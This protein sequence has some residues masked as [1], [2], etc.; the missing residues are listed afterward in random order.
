M[1]NT[2]TNNLQQFS[3]QDFID[4][5]LTK[6]SI[7]SYSINKKGKLKNDS[8][9][10]FRQQF[11]I[12]K[13]K[14][15]GL[16]SSII[17]QSHGPS[18]LTWDE[19]ETYYDNNGQVIKE[20]SRPLNI[21]K[22]VE[23]G[24]TK[25]DVI[26]YETD[27]EYDSL[28][29]EIKKTYK[30]IDHYY[31]ISKHTKDTFHLH[32]IERPDID[33]YFYN[34][35]N[36]KVQWFRTV[37]STRYLKTENY[38]PEKDSNAV[39]CYYCHSRYLNVEWKYN[40]DKKLTEWISYTSENFIHTKQNYFYDEQ[41]RLIKQIDSTG[42]YFTTI[43]PYQES[44][45]TIQYADTGKIVAKIYNPK[46]RFAKAIP[47]INSYFDNNDR[48]I[49]QCEFFDTEENCTQHAFIYDK[50]KIIKEEIIFDDGTLSSTEFYYNEKGLIRENRIF[51]N[52]NLTTL[53]R[54][55]YELNHQ[56]D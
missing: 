36:Q 32:I 54:Y 17:Y 50:N 4:N 43:R 48:L 52:G 26:T 3:R 10:L 20:I 15:F 53:I 8:L 55:Y 29:R 22:S 47:K 23:F 49:K 34:S 35:D 40:A 9:L 27:Y 7:Y 11:D 21:E 33:E 19:F 37:D 56:Q 16:N 14:L 38:N 18:S 41:Q 13:N 1:F 39:W 46:E 25:Y 5:N 31:S 6:V 12:T 51:R 42:W 30:K 44:T 24:S 2:G 28:Q 45:T